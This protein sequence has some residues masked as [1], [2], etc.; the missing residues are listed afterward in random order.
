MLLQNHSVFI[1]PAADLDMLK[2][3]PWPNGWSLPTGDS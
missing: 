3:S 1:L 2:H